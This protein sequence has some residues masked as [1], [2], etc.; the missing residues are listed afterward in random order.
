MPVRV[1]IT[2]A[3]RIKH[4]L[5]LLESPMRDALRNA[6]QGGALAVER[7][8]KNSVQR[9]SPSGRWYEKYKPRRTHRA[10]APG[11]PPATDTGFLVAHITTVIDMDGLGANVESQAAYSKALEFGTSKMAARPFLFPAFERLKPRILEQIA[12]ALRGPLRA[13]KG[14]K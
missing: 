10:S 3:E 4:K 1:T 11:Q 8:A 14:A 2:G 6:I 13:S 7:D 12:K 5:A 9:G